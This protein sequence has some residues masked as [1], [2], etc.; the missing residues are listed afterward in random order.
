MK[1]IEIKL[2]MLDMSGD[3]EGTKE[4][5]LVLGFS[6]SPLEISPALAQKFANILYEYVTIEEIDDGVLIKILNPKRERK[7]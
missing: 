1:G 2:Y 7:Q 4:G 6:G 5:D 3:I